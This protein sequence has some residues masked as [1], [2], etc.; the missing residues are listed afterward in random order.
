MYFHFNNH[1]FN[2]HTLSLKNKLQKYIKK[3]CFSQWA[4][5]NSLKWFKNFCTSLVLILFFLKASL[6]WHNFNQ[7]IFQESRSWLVLYYSHSYCLNIY[8]QFVPTY[9]AIFF[10]SLSFFFFELYTC[11]HEII[12]RWYSIFMCDLKI[13]VLNFGMQVLDLTVS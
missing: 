11:K 3:F 6:W 10:S 2:F 8:F 12:G 1:A 4:F 9:F 5:E 7:L 13:L